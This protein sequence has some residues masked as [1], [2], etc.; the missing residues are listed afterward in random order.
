MAAIQGNDVNVEI[1]TDNGTTFKTL[2]CETRSGV[3]I[4]RETSSTQT[5]CNAGVAQLGIGALSWSLSF[6]AV[7]DTDPSAS[8]VTYADMLTLIT[9]GTKVVGRI[10]YNTSGTEFYHKGDVYVTD[11]TLDAATGETVQF[12]GTLSGTGALDVTP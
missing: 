3:S 4:Q 11:L 6:D 10:Q 5:K 12:S 8:Q 9:A 2:I 1:S 7:A